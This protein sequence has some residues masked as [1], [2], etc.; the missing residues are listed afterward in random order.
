MTIQI[1]MFKQGVWVTEIRIYKGTKSL[2]SEDLFTI[3]DK[4]KNAKILT[5]GD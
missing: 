5:D 4:R 3:P 1:E 2:N